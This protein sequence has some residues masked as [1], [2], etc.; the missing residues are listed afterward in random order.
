MQSAHIASD[1]LH[2]LNHGRLLFLLDYVEFSGINDY[3]YVKK[4]DYS[5]ILESSYDSE[6]I[7]LDHDIL[8][9]LMPLHHKL[10]EQHLKN[11][12]NHFEHSEYYLVNTKTG[13]CMCLNYIWNGSFR[14]TCKHC[15]A[16]LIH[17]EAITSSNI[18]LFKQEV[19][20][21]LVQYFKNKQRV[22]PAESKNLLIYNGDVETAYLEIVNLYNIHGN[23][24]FY[25]V[26]LY[27]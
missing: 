24:S 9:L 11:V 14:D 18:L 25:F 16:A 1:K 23:F 22:L 8:N 4:G 17:K 19:K 21:D 6:L 26:S 20:K 15:H 12:S 27:L 13:E 3:F 10:M 5:L 7:R 2:R